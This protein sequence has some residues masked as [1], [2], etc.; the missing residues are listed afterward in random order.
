MPSSAR[1]RVCGSRCAPRLVHCIC[2]RLAK[3]LL[4]TAFTAD[5]PRQ[6]EIG[7]PVGLEAAG[8]LAIG[9]RWEELVRTRDV[10]IFGRRWKVGN[11]PV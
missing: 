6:E 7:A 1:V 3:R 9:G 8:D 2:W 4:M 10:P 5:S 11:H